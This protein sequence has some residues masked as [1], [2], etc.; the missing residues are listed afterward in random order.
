[1]PKVKTTNNVYIPMPVALIGANVHGKANF[2]PVG[3][4]TR[5]N[6]Q[7]PM[8]AACINKVHYTPL[9]IRENNTFSVCLPGPDM[10]EKTDYCGLV[11]GEET[12]KSAVFSVFYGE[13]KTAPMIEQSPLC[14][15]CKL[16]EM[17]E[18]PTNVIYIGEIAG[19]Y[20]EEK[21]LTNG[22]FDVDKAEPL[23]LTMPDN[24]Y[25]ALGR[26]VAK[27]WGVGMKL[28]KAGK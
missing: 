8:M 7:P 3:W 1:M 15:E 16:V 14:I 20:A 13:T 27:A 24:E 17:V 21:Y 25:R 6:A 19:V 2:M 9:G 22:K 12:D 26:V 18:L 11:S 28:K 5:A 23:L 10:A 4:V